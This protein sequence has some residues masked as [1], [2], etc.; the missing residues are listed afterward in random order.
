MTKPDGKRERNKVANR[1]AILDAARKCFL[2]QGYD[3]V[4]IRDVVRLSGLAAGTFYNYFRTKEE[5]LRALIET[6]VEAVTSELG[7]LRRRARNL[8]EFLH[9]AYLA[10]FTIVAAEPVLY[11]LMLRNEPAVRALYKESVLGVSV[12]A[13]KEDLRDAMTRGI[14]PRMDIDYLAAAL[15]GAGYEMGRVLAE[16]PG[17]DP[18]TVADFITR[19]FMGGIVAFTSDKQVSF[20][21]RVRAAP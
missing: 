7:E 8:Q 12:R 14:M 16:N 10:G 4:T 2:Q 5:L 15:F 18:R 6:R 1:T 13:L 11:N 20:K 3:A 9:G 21:P 17:R 19:L